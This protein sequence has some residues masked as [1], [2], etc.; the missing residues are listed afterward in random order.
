MASPKLKDN[1][2]VLALSAGMIAAGGLLATKFGASAGGGKLLYF[3]G[4]ALALFGL[5]GFNTTLWAM[6]SGAGKRKSGTEV[7]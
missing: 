6:I 4:V 1:L 5:L 2:A 7:R 3:A